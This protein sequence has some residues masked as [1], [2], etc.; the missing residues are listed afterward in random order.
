MVNIKKIPTLLCLVVVLLGVSPVVA[1]I[2]NMQDAY[3]QALKAKQTNNVPQL[4]A[5]LKDLIAFKPSNYR[6]AVLTQSLV[7][8]LE[9]NLKDRASTSG[10]VN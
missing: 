7:A 5:L 6:E 4:N 9:K 8:D 3:D 1:A 2:K 10:P